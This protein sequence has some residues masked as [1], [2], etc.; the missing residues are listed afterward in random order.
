MYERIIQIDHETANNSQLRFA[1]SEKIFWIIISKK[2]LDRVNKLIKEF[3][4]IEGPFSSFTYLSLMRNYLLMD[5][6][7]KAKIL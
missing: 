6:F 1:I 3:N 5:E 2:G 7:E 4:Q